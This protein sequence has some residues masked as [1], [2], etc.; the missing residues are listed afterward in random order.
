MGFAYFRSMRRMLSNPILGSS[1]LENN[2]SFNVVI[3]YEDFESGTHAKRTYDLLAT[4]LG[5]DCRFW[6]H[7][8]KFD[9]LSIPK[10]ADVAA[11]DASSADIVIV[12]CH[13]ANPLAEPVKNWFESWAQQPSRAIALIVLF[14][15]AEE[16]LT[17]S[18][19][20]R[21]YFDALARQGNMEFFSQPKDPAW[22][23]GKAEHFVFERRSG[24][25]DKALFT[26]QQATQ[27]EPVPPRWGINE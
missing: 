6:N 17:T 19:E 12:S 26:L 25:A 11:K 23:N 5:Q 13:G 4:N 22:S 16:N 27:E 1:D 8:W 10:L 3:V 20:I 24:L 9:V 18:R 15:H 2:S 14:T 21:H 7:M